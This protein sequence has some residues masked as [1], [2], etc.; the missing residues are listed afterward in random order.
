MTN[1]RG[2]HYPGTVRQGATGQLSALSDPP[3]RPTRPPPPT[4]ERGPTMSWIKRVEK[5]HKC[6]FP[7]KNL[8]T[9]TH[10]AY[11]AEPGDIWQCPDCECYWRLLPSDN[12]Q[13]ANIAGPLHKLGNILAAAFRPH[14]GD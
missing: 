7:A 14:P 12:W 5:P 1:R 9:G 4:T 10:W 6:R 11:P 3:T 2:T 8:W 13:A